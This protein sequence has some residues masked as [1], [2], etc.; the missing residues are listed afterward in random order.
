MDVVTPV[1]RQ[2]WD[3]IVSLSEQSLAFHRPE[4]MD[5]ICRTSGFAEATRLYVRP[6]RRIVV[7]LARRTG[8]RG[9]GGMVASLPYG[10]GFGGAI[11]D[12]P[13]EDDDVAA[14]TADL[15]AQG[16]LR[17]S[18]RPDPRFAG[19]WAP[20]F[21]PHVVR[22]PR[23]A[24]VL[25]LAGGF[26]TVWSRRFTSDCRR[27]VRRA[28]RS[29]ISVEVGH[30]PAALDVFA[31]LYARST[32]RWARQAGSAPVRWWM[33]ARS[34]RRAKFDAAAAALGD[35]LDVWIAR[36]G[37][38]PVA[39]VV[40]LSHGS[41][42]SYWRGAMDEAAAGRTRANYLLHRL[43]IE[44]ACQAGRGAY[45]M[46]DTGTSAS[47]AQFKTRFGAVAM[48]YAE[49]RAERLPL[50]QG[51]RVA[52][53]AVEGVVGSRVGDPSSVASAGDTARGSPEGSTDAQ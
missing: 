45:H 48:D 22:I 14:I 36:E 13:L 10:W 25:D 53:R 20:A 16:W 41:A 1:R 4:W 5:A 28:E 8:P 46:G 40:V 49:F 2:D 27:H 12:G 35:A 33:R 31:D 34:E 19:P 23:R 44:A 52:R 42:A 47:L 38:R 15:T 24:H 6:G 11:A 30:G 50:T 39:A 3:E 7:P 29:G 9:L 26:D 17:L 21:G 43:A 18:V 37:D 32:E 51:T